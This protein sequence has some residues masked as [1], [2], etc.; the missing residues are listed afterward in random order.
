MFAR[1]L[2]AEHNLILVARRRDRQKALADEFAST[3][4][5]ESEILEADLAT[6][7]GISVVADRIAAEPNLALLV[8]NAG[9]GTRGLFWECSLES[10]MQ[11]HKLHVMATTQLTHAALRSMVP[12]NFGAII[13]VASV[14]AFVRRGG[15]ASYSA[16][17][18][19]MTA[20]TEG[21]YLELKGANSNVTVQALCPGF[22]YSE[23]HDKAGIDRNKTASSAWWLTAEEVVDASLAGLAKRKLFVIPGWRYRLFTAAFSKLPSAVRL[24]AESGIL[25]R[26]ELPASAPVGSRP[27]GPAV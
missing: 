14:S 23:F 26:N 17:K 6:D 11:M 4:G 20:F 25:K 15:S 24:A 21:I 18:T 1:R 16:T 10:Q 8:N 22:T 2:A 5:T 7:A 9:F 12:K 27:L 19:W 13:N 3:Y